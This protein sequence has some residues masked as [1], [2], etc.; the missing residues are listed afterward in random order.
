MAFQNRY[1]FTEGEITMARML[2]TLAREVLVNIWIIIV[3]LALALAFV[4]ILNLLKV[5]VFL[6]ANGDDIR[7]LGGRN[8]SRNR[9]REDR[10]IH[11]SMRVL[12]QC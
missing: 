5:R 3:L 11:Q 6:K 2:K 7:L 4:E 8:T 12:A 9:S 10:C 1:K